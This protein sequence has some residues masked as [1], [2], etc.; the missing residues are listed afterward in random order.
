MVKNPCNARDTG[1]IP[2]QRTEISYG[3]HGATKLHVKELSPC[4][5]PA[6]E[7]P[8]SAVKILHAT[9][10]TQYGQVNKS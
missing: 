8:C 10:K 2:G 7:S 4:T 3:C 9:T 5:A 1:L 6:L